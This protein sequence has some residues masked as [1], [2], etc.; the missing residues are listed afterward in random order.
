MILPILVIILVSLCLYLTYQKNMD[1]SNK[2]IVIGCAILILHISFNYI[3][4]NKILFQTAENFQSEVNVTKEEVEEEEQESMIKQKIV[5]SRSK[6]LNLEEL[7][8]E[9]NITSP[10]YDEVDY[11]SD[12]FDNTYDNTDSNIIYDNTSIDD[13]VDTPNLDRFSNTRK[14]KSKKEGFKD[15]L[16]SQSGI[17]GTG[18]IFTP[19]IIIQNDEN[20]QSVGMRS[21]PNEKVQT[22]YKSNKNWQTPAN[23]LYGDEEI[24]YTGLGKD[25]WDNVEEN[26]RRSYR[27]HKEDKR[28]CGGLTNPFKASDS[29]IEQNN[30]TMEKNRTNYRPGYSFMPPTEWDVPQERPPVCIPDKWVRP[31]AVFDRGTPLNVLELDEN[32]DML[33][34]ENRVTF[35]NVGSIMPRFRYEEFTSY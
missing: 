34:D 12:D 1:T 26:M 6:N 30:R 8:D 10:S 27:Q 15:T 9:I 29:S 35:T 2:I 23:N 18:N 13:L 24:P 19:Q 17:D 20:G 3:K 21:T 31:S 7:A 28:S 4:N 22:V 33:M 25:P 32:G 11:D 14:E 5:K 16:V